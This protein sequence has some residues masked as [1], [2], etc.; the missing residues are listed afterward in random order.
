ML[1]NPG[2]LRS[3]DDYAPCSMSNYETGNWIGH[4]VVQTAANLGDLL[5]GTACDSDATTGFL[6]QSAI[7]VK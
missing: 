3:C 2:T 1:K 6:L 5:D 7:Y 4:A